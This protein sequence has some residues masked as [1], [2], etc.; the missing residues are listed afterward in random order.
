MEIRTAVLATCRDVAREQRKQLVQL[1]D[2]LPLLE[3]GLDSLC[4][5]VI[6][7]RMDDFL[8]FDPF[9]T[10][11]PIDF[12]VTVGDFIAF[13]EHAAAARFA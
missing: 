1:S 10:K 6:V 2:D 7:A 8:G 5:A 11:D 12:P 3:S 4:I 9:D 13:Y